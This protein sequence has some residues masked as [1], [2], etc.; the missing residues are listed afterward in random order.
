VFSG[1]CQLTGLAQFAA[2][3]APASPVPAESGFLQS[4]G[5]Q[6][7][8]EAANKL[9]AETAAAVRRQRIASVP[10]FYG[11]FAFEGK[12]FHFTLV[13][14]SPQAGGTIQIRSMVFAVLLI[15]V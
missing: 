15:C 11:S 8:F 12:T 4:H 3:G 6:P 10:H 9:S 2:Q 5:A 7:R 14:A 13:G 1:C